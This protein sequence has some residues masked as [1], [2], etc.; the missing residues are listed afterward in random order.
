[1]KQNSRSLGGGNVPLSLLV[2]LQLNE[3]NKG[4]YNDLFKKM[5]SLKVS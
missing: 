4:N 1:M 2:K 3:K 5:E